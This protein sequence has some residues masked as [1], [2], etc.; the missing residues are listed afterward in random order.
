MLAAAKYSLT[1]GPQFDPFGVS[2][3]PIC[4]SRI[5]GSEKQS[6]EE[7][8]AEHRCVP[9]TISNAKGNFLRRKFF[10]ISNHW[11]NRKN[12]TKATKGV[13][14]ACG[15]AGTGFRLQAS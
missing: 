13:A 5:S 4:V 11:E 1:L 7:D 3:T 10:T 6:L 12:A 9:S 2:E 8:E 14:L 15:W